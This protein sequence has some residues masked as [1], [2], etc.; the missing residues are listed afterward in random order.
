[1]AYGYEMKMTPLQMLTFYNAVANN[2]KMVAPLFVREIRR[3]GNTVERFDPR[4][5]ENKICSDATLGKLQDLLLGVV[6]EGTGRTII[7]NP[8]YKIAG[9]TGTAQIADG[10][11][12]YR[13]NRSYQAS[14]CGYFPADNPKYSMIVVITNPSKGSYYA[15]QVAGPVFR[16]VADKIY[17]NDIEMYNPVQELKLVGNT[18][19]PESKS[20]YK[21]STQKVYKAL[22]IK[23]YLAGNSDFV[24]MVDTNNGVAV[25]DVKIVPQTVPDVTGMGLKDAVYLLSSVGL[26]PV[27]KGSGRVTKQSVEPGIRTAKGYPVTIELN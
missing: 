8:S 9:K 20:G 3:L 18:K 25:K 11:K 12:G 19:M 21:Q 5:I 4:V 15:A 26:K 13:I 22:G 10:A 23:A 2:G 17:S 16:E 1:M 27:V 24:N 6:E 7:K 14:F